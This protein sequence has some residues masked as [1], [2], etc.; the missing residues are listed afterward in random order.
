MDIKVESDLK[1]V[2]HFTKKG[3][4]NGK[5]Y[6]ALV[7]EGVDKQYITVEVEDLAE[8]PLVLKWDSFMYVGNVLGNRL[9]CAYK[10]TRNFTATKVSHGSDQPATVATRKVSGRPVSQQ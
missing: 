8:T 2:V 1:T 10:V 6:D 9:T 4:S 7:V 3:A 5:D